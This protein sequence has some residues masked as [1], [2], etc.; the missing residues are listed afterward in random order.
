M[1]LQCGD[2]PKQSIPFIDINPEA[3]G[4]REEMSGLHQLSVFV[5]IALVGC[6]HLPLGET[7]QHLEARLKNRRSQTRVAPGMAVGAQQ[8]CPFSFVT[9]SQS[10]SLRQLVEA[11]V[12]SQATM[13][14]RT[15]NDILN[16]QLQLK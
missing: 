15:L 14:S 1:G 13:N 5:L 4:P 7:K 9:L 11:A 8:C 2:R 12:A 16:E 6:A 3:A 10:Q